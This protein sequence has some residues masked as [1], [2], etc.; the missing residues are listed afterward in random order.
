MAALARA[1]AAEANSR[2]IRQATSCDL[3]TKALVA[4]T[5]MPEPDLRQKLSLALANPAQAAPFSITSV[6]AQTLAQRPDVFAA[7]RDVVVASAQV[8]NAKAQR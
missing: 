8:G 5:A 3:D 6:P 2:A 1:S 4:L 7:E